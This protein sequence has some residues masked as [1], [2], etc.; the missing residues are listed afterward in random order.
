MA[1]GHLDRLSSIDAGFL[2]VEEDGAHMHIGALAVFA[3]P[4]PTIEKFRHHI[5]ARLPRLPRYR[6]RVQEMPFGTGRPLWVEDSTFRLDFH[7]RHT[8]LPAPGGERELL[9]LVD[10]VVGQRLDRSKPL[11]EIWLVEGLQDGRWAMVGKTHHAMIDG[12][13]GVDLIS[14]LF[15]LSPDVPA[16]AVEPWEARREPG[17]VDLLAGGVKGLLRNGIGLAEQMTKLVRDPRQTVESAVGSVSA[18]AEAVRPLVDAAPKTVLN[19]RP[20]PHRRVEVVRTDL[21]DYKK[22]KESSGGATVNDV[23]LTAVAGALGRFLAS[24][25]SDVDGLTLRA[26]VPVSLRQEAKR[27]ALGN[28]IAIMNADLPVGVKDPQKRLALVR[29]GMEHL[30]SSKQ[31]EGAKV[32]T[33]LENAL[34][35]AVLARASRLGFSSRL[36]NL[37]VT[38]VPGPQFPIYMLGRRLEEL[39]PLAFLAPEHTLAIGIMSYDGQVAYGLLGDADALPDLGELAQHLRDCLAELVATAS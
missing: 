23:V 5:E 26:C 1:Q 18:L 38:N 4:A 7:V 22:V 28:E 39:V 32:L 6:Q 36:Y 27:G 13:S 19:S 34:P 9:N 10:R 14:V 20:G 3:G 15:D 35:P 29:K 31:A 30:K 37:L 8:A 21:A 16:E 24:R 25:G 17:A 11:W 33:S 2:H 12:V